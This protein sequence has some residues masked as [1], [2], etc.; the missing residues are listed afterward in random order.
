ME[1]QEESGNV[2]MGG[3][4]VDGTF[5]GMSGF[6]LWVAFARPLVAVL[7]LEFHVNTFDTD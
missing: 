5:N 2:Y 7:G 4:C 3:M 6:L 1:R